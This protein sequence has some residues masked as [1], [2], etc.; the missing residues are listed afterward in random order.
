MFQKVLL[1][2][3]AHID[4]AFTEGYS[5]GCTALNIATFRGHL[6]IVEVRL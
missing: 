4:A 1:A 5:L 2:N 6:Q 3:G